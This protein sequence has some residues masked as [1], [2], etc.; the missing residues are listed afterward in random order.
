MKVPI[1]WLKDYVEIAGSPADL[2]KALIMA[3]VGVE[4][5]EGDVLDLEI[6]A[7][8]ADLLS[9]TGVAREVGVVRRTPSKRPEVSYPEGTEEVSCAVEV[10]A[11]DLCPR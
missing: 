6:T 4:A 5:V 9:M 7:N 2:A 3:G 1:G 10:A 8:R 11:P